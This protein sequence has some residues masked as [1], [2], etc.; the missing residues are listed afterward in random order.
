MSLRTQNAFPVISALGSPGPVHGTR[1]QNKRNPTEGRKLVFKQKTEGAA[2]KN[3]KG[4]SW[5]RWVYIE[6]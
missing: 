6:G 2:I 5:G 1:K 4:S 3:R